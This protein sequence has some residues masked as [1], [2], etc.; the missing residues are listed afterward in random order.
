MRKYLI[1]ALLFSSSMALSPARAE[2]TRFFCIDEAA[3]T[4]IAR[5]VLVSQQAA[6]EAATPYVDQGVCMYLPRNVHVDIVYRGK[7]FGRANFAV[8][9]IGFMDAGNGHMLYGLLSQNHDM[10]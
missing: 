8:E 10:I 5:Q 9:I 7:L 1:A 6:D 2:E 4:A 3:A